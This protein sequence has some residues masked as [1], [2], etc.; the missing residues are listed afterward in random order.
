[1]IFNLWSR[2]LIKVGDDERH[3]FDRS[4]LMYTEVA[5]IEKVSGLSFGEWERELSRY[6]IT[7]IAPLIHVLRKRDGQASDFALMQFNAASLDVVPLHDDGTEYTT[8]EA[9]EELERRLKNAAAETDPTG[10]GDAP[11]LPPP[12]DTSI[13]S[14]SSLNGSGSGRGNGTGSAGMTSGSAKRTSMRSSTGSSS[15][16]G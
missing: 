5:E 6:S 7:A 13:T 12:E 15:R 1:M 10:G 14:R 2:L 16:R 9:A 3:V 11:A 4:R 8:A